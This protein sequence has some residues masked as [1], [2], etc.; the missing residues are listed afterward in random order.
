M[1]CD[2]LEGWDRVGDERWLQEGGDMYTLKADSCGYVAEAN[3][4]L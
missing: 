3:I 4:M 2:N 1:L